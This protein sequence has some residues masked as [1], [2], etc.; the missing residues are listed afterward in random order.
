MSDRK[1]LPAS[2][3]AKIWDSLKE[4]HAAGDTSVK[5]DRDSWPGGFTVQFSDEVSAVARTVSHEVASFC[6]TVAA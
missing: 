1:P 5:M 3:A 6:G 4:R 2:D